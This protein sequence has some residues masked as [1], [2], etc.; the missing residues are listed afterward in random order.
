MLTDVDFNNFSVSEGD[1]KTHIL[2]IVILI[3]FSKFKIKTTINSKSIF[4]T[5]PTKFV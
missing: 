3:S 1:S 2:I 4:L 5:K